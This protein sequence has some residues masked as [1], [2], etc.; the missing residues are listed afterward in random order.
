M[1]EGGVSSGHC[2]VFS[3]RAV[4]APGEIDDTQLLKQEGLQKKGLYNVGDEWVEA[5]CASKVVRY[6]SW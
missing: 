1:H 2:S 5:T 6:N 4:G 3:M